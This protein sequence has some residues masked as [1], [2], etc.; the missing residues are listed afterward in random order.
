MSLLSSLFGRPAPAAP[1]A[2]PPQAPGRTLAGR[3][4]DDHQG[5]DR[6]WAAVE[7]AVEADQDPGAAWAAFS[8][9]LLTHLDAEERLL[10][11]EIER[12]TGFGGGPV[13]VMRMEHEQMRGLVRG[14]EAHAQHGA[15]S[16]LL[17]DGDTLLMLIGQHNMKEEGVLYPMAEQ[18]LAAQ[19]AELLPRLDA[20][21]ARP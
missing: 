12:A 3:L 17:A 9:S 1:A 20:A 21:L 4:T 18:L 8:A 14:L 13:A 11:P 19:L 10:F 5:C 2:T 15:W 6:L 7:E 16:E